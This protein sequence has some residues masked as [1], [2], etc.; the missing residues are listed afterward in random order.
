MVPRVGDAIPEL[1][2]VPDA[3]APAR[4]AA[5]SGDFNPLHLDP[6][7]ARDVAGLP[8]PILHGL[9]AMCLLAQA[10][11]EAADGDPRALKRL[12]AEFSDMAYPEHELVVRGKVAEVSDGM[13]V[14]DCTIEQEGREVISAR[15]DL[16]PDP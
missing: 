13:A 7:Y 12:S 9:Y 1:R 5:V 15:A 3:T 2:V 6:A 8:G 16:A 14:L 10:T 4:Y 11:V